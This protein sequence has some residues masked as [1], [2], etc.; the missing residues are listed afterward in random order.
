VLDRS[1]FSDWVFAEKN[2]LDGNIDA[3][4]FF[5]YTKLR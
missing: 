4:G 3:D 1:I 5:Y 2:R